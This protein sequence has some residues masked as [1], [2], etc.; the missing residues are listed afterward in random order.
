MPCAGAIL[1][2]C[3]LLLYELAFF[4]IPPRLCCHLFPVSFFPLSFF[5]GLRSCSRGSDDDNFAELF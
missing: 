4:S 5:V 1:L 3:P 2:V